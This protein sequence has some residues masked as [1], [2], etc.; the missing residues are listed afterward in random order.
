[1]NTRER[2]IVSYQLRK[3]GVF[4]LVKKSAWATT[5]LYLKQLVRSD[6]PYATQLATLTGID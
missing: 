1:M 5:E 6:N 4:V 2:G 3:T